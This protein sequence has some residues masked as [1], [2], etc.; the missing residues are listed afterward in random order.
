MVVLVGTRDF[1]LYNLAIVRV[2]SGVPRLTRGAMVTVYTSHT[3]VVYRQ[4]LTEAACGLEFCLEKQ[5]KSS[6]FSRLFVSTSS[7]GG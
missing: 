7:G 2:G 3:Y 5:I 6:F 1:R 4:P